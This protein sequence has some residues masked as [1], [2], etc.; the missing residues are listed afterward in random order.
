MCRLSSGILMNGI[1]D[2]WA[3]INWENV[4]I[5]KRQQHTWLYPNFLYYALALPFYIFQLGS[6]ETDICLS[7]RKQNEKQ[8]LFVNV[9][10]EIAEDFK[11]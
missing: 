8:L 4:L 1:T 10:Y 5:G 2:T 6:T 9:L 7:P 11:S 3:Y